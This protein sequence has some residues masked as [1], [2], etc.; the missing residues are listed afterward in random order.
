MTEK[1]ESPGGVARALSGA[2]EPEARVEG[3]RVR[4]FELRRFAAPFEALRDAARARGRCDGFA[5]AEAGT[6]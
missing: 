1:R 5:E 4:P 3:V 6:A 2:L